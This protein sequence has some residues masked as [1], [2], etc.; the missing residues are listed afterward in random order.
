VEIL[1]FQYD[2]SL[3]K[4]FK[5]SGSETQLLISG[6]RK[7]V[8]FPDTVFECP[9]IVVDL[10]DSSILRFC[11]LKASCSAI[12]SPIDF[13]VEGVTYAKGMYT[14]LKDKIAKFDP[15]L[16]MSPGTDDNAKD[17][18]LSLFKEKSLL[19]EIYKSLMS[20]IRSY[21]EPKIPDI[22]ICS[23]NK[24]IVVEK[25]KPFLK[26][27]VDLLLPKGQTGE[28]QKSVLEQCE[29]LLELD[30][31]EE[32]FSVLDIKRQ[33]QN[34]EYVKGLLNGF[35][36][37]KDLVGNFKVDSNFKIDSKVLFRLDF[38]DN[39]PMVVVIG[40][41]DYVSNDVRKK[42]VP[43]G[44][45]SDQPKKEKS[46]A[47]K[48]PPASPKNPRKTKLKHYEY[49]KPDNIYNKHERNQSEATALITDSESSRSSASTEETEDKTYSDDLP[50]GFTN[51]RIEK[52]EI[53]SDKQKHQSELKNKQEKSI[54]KSIT[55]TLSSD[56]NEKKDE[57]LSDRKRKQ[58]NEE[59]YSD[60]LP[61]GFT[62]SR[63]EEKEITSD[64]QKHQSEFKNKQE[65]SISK[66][67]TLTLNSDPNEKKDEPLSD[68]KRKQKNEETYS[69]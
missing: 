21:I 20:G 58:K 42:F 53:T 63:I 41:R 4:T 33:F 23:K 54:S 49:S 34:I 60:D 29:K 50:E 27:A 57:P 61:E 37:Y 46:Q 36:V 38:G 47:K 55:H 24:S 7:R 39:G 68:R 40:E 64:K 16:L 6:G 43:Y 52:K 31:A 69:D 35:G 8:I 9:L 59:T 30:S 14:I 5:L 17:E 3:L 67:I 22:R 45:K 18:T 65:K 26:R 15:D 56:S 28:L 32:Y 19:E 48:I 12:F 44:E 11:S 66:S 1:D 10:P 25:T 2:N 51:S 13:I 62:N